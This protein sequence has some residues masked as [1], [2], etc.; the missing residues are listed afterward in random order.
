MANQI[1]TLPLYQDL[2]Q[3][4]DNW[5]TSKQTTGHESTL[6]LRKKA[7][8]HFRT[9]G[10]P[11]RK[12][13]D[14]KYT[15]VLPFLQQSYEFNP[16]VIQNTDKAAIALD[17]INMVGLDAYRVVL[18]NG[19][20]QLALSDE[21]PAGITLKSIAEAEN[22]PAFQANFG[23]QINLEKYHFAAL[24]TAWYANGL[25][26]EVL[27]NTVLEK[28]IYLVH[29]YTGS[30]NLFIQ[31]RNLVVVN[32]SASVSIVE[33]VIADSHN[34]DIFVN[35]VSEIVVKE[36]AQVHHYN[37]Q[38][39]SKNTRQVNHTEVSQKRDSVYS[40]YTFSL[41]EADLLRNNLHLNLNDEYTESHLYGLYLLNGRQ[42]TDNHTL[43][44]HLHPH[45]ESNEVYKGVLL[46]NANGVFNGKIFVQRDAQK[47]NAF[48]Q[49]NNLLLSNKATIN[50]KP[51]LE[52][53]ADDVKCSHGS[54]VGQLSQE[55]MFYL[56]SR[57]ISEQTARRLL[58]SAF[59][60]DVT[61][62]IRIPAVEA[63]INKLITQHI[64][65]E[66]ELVKA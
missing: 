9:L 7:M 62:N 46:D 63:Y 8:E 5:L 32:R 4:F 65:A 3:G 36:N 23:Q 27:A 59:A 14:W 10:F 15:N 48:Q 1:S 13:E 20:V 29:I 61:Q 35:S 49:N 18:V 22:E 16:D 44:N 26:L 43:V 2:L 42:L 6:P 39:N 33:S 41:P 51:Q 54:T 58:V 66:Q 52:I 21:L 11:S 28:P 31:P 25:F 56:R 57:G 40:N 50:S 34:G 17:N 19:Q 64:P 37:L 45:C 55:A 30:G 12:V 60:F 47:T 53:F 38:N 24:N